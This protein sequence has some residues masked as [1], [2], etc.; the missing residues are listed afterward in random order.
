MKV[1]PKIVYLHIFPS[2]L[3]IHLLAV[4]AVNLT[5]Y[6]VVLEDSYGPLR[7]GTNNSFR[8]ARITVCS[9]FW[10]VD[11][12]VLV[13]IMVVEP[14]MSPPNPHALKNN[15]TKVENINCCSQRNKI[16]HSRRN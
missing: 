9:H 14:R 11:Q 13:Y 16:R 3:K 5:L 12:A 7:G 1:D 10:V 15:L 4:H 2:H 6:I 8:P